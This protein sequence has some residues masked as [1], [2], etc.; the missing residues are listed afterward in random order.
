MSSSS[1]SLRR[2]NVLVQIVLADVD[3][4][5]GVVR[6]IAHGLVNTTRFRPTVAAPVL[7]RLQ[8][9]QIITSV[10]RKAVLNCTDFYE[11]LVKASDRSRVLF[12][13]S[14]GRSSRFAVVVFE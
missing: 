13:I 5:R 8:P 12:L 7:A 9:G 6:A 2:R 3:T 11:A 14:D 10:N 4:A 1:S